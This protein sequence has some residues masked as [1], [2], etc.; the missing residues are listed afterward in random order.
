MY[1]YIL[2]GGLGLV[3]IY[4]FFFKKPSRTCRIR[5]G[6]RPTKYAKQSR[7]VSPKKP[8]EGAVR[9]GSEAPEGELLSTLKGGRVTTLYQS[10][11]NARSNF[12]AYPCLGTRSFESDGSRGHF[13]WKS[14]MEIANKRNHFAAGLTH[15]GV[16]PRDCVGIYAKN[17]EEWIVTEQACYASSFVL[18]SFYDTLGEE[19]VEYICNHSEARIVVSSKE[20]TPK[21]LAVRE[22]CAQL[23]II[24]Q[25]ENPDAAQLEQAAAKNI[26]LLSFAEVLK[27]GQ[28]NPH[29]GQK[30]TPDDLSTIMYTSGTTGDPKGVL[31]THRN[32]VSVM[33]A[34]ELLLD[35]LLTMG[36]SYLSYL[37]LAH[38]FER[39]VVNTALYRGCRVGFYQGDVRKIIDDVAE[40]KPHFF[41]AVPRVFDRVHDKIV[42]MVAQG[43][44]VKRWLFERAMKA[45]AESIRTGKPVWWLWDKLILSKVRARLGGNVAAMLSGSAPLTAPVQEFMRTAFGCPVMQ[46][47]GLTETCAGA[48]IGWPRDSVIG[49]A[50]APLACCEIKLVDVPEMGYTSEGDV[51]TGEVVMRGPNVSQG[52]YKDPKKTAEDF[53]DGWF[54]TGDIGRWNKDGTLSII[55]RKKNI[56]KL[57]QGEY[58]AAEKLEGVYGRSKYVNG[59]WV[60]G[61]STKFALVAVAYPDPETLLPWAKENGLGSDMVALCK[62]KKVV[63]H[64]F[65]DLVDTGKQAKLRGFELIQRLHLHPEE[66]S[67]GLNLITPTFKLRRPQL[68]HHFQSTIDQLYAD[69]DASSQAS[70]SSSSS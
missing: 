25:M 46:G 43:G 54:H 4:L 57:S 41:A 21:I 20:S 60:Y 62:N 30:P 70:A 63:D 48:T 1:T 8:G 55:D 44:A 61:D 18:V 23:K 31:L 17:R 59:I 45:S 2:T 13:Q 52:Y 3:L 37:P 28:A 14:F 26:R 5:M 11:Q 32:C 40:L 19:A 9:R 68:L 38:I 50:G 39:A 33:A 7:E 12:G 67:I 69:I 65:K 49:H 47:Y 6:P 64:V 53:V 51:E 10:F 66:F 42:N 16:K 34:A 36:D 56:F 15:L 58:V 22:K 24:I 35:G 29:D 27:T